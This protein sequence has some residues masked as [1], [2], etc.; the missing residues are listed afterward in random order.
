MPQRKTIGAQRVNTIRS[1]APW[2]GTWIHLDAP[3][4]ERLRPD[5]ELH[6][7]VTPSLLRLCGSRNQ[8]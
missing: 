2:R 5:H 3:L 6:R 7:T 8:Y 4:P 1:I